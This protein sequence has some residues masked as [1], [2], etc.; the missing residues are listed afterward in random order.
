MIFEF[1]ENLHLRVLLVDVKALNEGM[2]DFEFL[3]LLVGAGC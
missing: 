1:E 2:S 3:E